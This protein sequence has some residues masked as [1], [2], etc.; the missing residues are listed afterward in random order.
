MNWPHFSMKNKITEGALSWKTKAPS[1]AR[2]PNGRPW[3]G[4]GHSAAAANGK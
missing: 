4:A 3:A 1:L 2:P